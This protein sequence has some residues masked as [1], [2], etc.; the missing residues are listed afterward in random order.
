M[1]RVPKTRPETAS[2]A[3]FL[4]SITDEA[5]RKECQ[6]V[7]RLM[8]QATGSKPQMWGTSIVGFGTRLGGGCTSGHAIAG[9]ADFQLGSLLAVCGFFAGGLIA[10]YF[11][12]PMILR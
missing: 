9:L 7:A 3:A 8:Q 12:L 2:V 10:T 4:D 1:T 5:R 6:A 11:V